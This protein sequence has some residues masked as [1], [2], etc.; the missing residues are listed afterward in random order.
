MTTLHVYSR[1]GC[2]LCEVLI[3]QLLPLT[4]GRIDVEVRDIDS[5]D[6]WRERF[7]VRV[8]VV[9]Y[10]DDVICEYHLDRD[11]LDGLLKRLETDT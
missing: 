7:D 1:Q 6:D 2:H 9:A 10:G 3:E 11:A 8:P 5:R 4:R